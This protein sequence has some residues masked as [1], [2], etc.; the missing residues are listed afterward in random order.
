MAAADAEVALSRRPERALSMPFKG[1]F[2][3]PTDQAPATVPARGTNA[4]V[5]KISRMWIF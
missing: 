5:R 4:L 1:A 3:G 2:N